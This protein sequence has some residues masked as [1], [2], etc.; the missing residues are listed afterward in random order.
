MT[1]RI[2]HQLKDRLSA[3]RGRAKKSNVA[4][5]CALCS[6]AFAIGEIIWVSRG[7]PA[8]HLRCTP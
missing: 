3:R 4:G 1:P 8:I 5:T 7:L 6:E 2:Y